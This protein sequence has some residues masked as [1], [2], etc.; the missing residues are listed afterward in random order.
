MRGGTAV[1]SRAGGAVIRVANGQGFWGDWLEAPVRL[2]EDGPIDYLTLDYLAEVTMSILQKQKARDAA[3]GYARDFP[4]LMARIEKSVK[5]RHVRVVANAGG[6]NPVACAREVRRLAP[7]LSVAVVTG[8]DLLPH[9]DAMIA[10]G[11]EFSN[12]DTH[13]P[14]ATIR[15]RVQS[16]NAYIG[17]H[18]LAGA[19]DT[20]VDVVISGRAADAALGLAPMVHAFGWQED[21]WDLLAAGTVA[22][23]IIECGA[24]STGGNCQKDWQSIPDLA[25]IGY[26][27]VEVES[28]G[29]AVV[30]KH[31]G[32]G[33]RVSLATVK[34]QLL[35]EISDPRAYITPDCIADFTT[36]HLEDAGRDRVRVSGVRGRARTPFLK[37]SAS[38]AA[39]WKAIGTL[40]Y[41][42]PDALAKATVAD[43]IVRTRLRELDLVFDE[44]HTEYFGVNALRAGALVP[45]PDPVEVQLRIG[46]RGQDRAMVDRF[47]REL[48]PLVLTGPPT[49]T[50]YGEG[51]PE[52]REV[53]AFWP[54]LVPRALVSPRV[55]LVA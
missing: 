10:T 30:T 14:L 23:H 26:P 33:G 38:Y 3:L 4:P 45:P 7:S 21:D 51:R 12:L 39:G 53:V 27:I 36:I 2:V 20:G 42:Q 44:I 5:A 34:E 18:A 49:A 16:A 19:L 17:A 24:H 6:V 32:S 48:I 55:E 22:G 15:N 35:Y 29:T 43:G 9:L 41:S 40:V 31:H 50:G 37:V 1:A 47:T 46:V 52:V 28:D 25:H 11:C 13:E 8:D 54:A